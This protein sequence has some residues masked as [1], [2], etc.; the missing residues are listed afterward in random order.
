MLGGGILPVVTRRA[1]SGC[2]SFRLAN[3]LAGVLRTGV[4]AGFGSW[5]GGRLGLVQQRLLGWWRG[6]R[7]CRTGLRLLLRL[8]RGGG[9]RRS[10]WNGRARFF[11]SLQLPQGLAIER[12]VGRLR[13]AIL[14][15]RRRL[16][17]SCN[18]FMRIRGQN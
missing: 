8:S 2:I 9:L 10:G 14:V 3:G 17:L 18:P 4:K 12:R 13:R 1:A 16:F 11:H 6:W 5:G 7:S 15:R